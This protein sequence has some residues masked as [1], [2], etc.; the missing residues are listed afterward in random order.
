MKYNEFKA[1]IEAN[2]NL[3]TYRS[4]IMDKNKVMNLTGHDSEEGVNA[5]LFYDSV[6]PF[7]ALGEKLSESHMLDIGSG[8]G[9]PGLVLK[10][11]TPGMRLTIIEAQEKRCKF[12]NDV[13]EATGITGVEI[14]H[15]RA[16]MFMPQFCEK[17]DIATA[18]AVARLN[19]LDEITAPYVKIGGL[20]I[21]PKGSHGEIELHE[22]KAGIHKLGLEI[23]D[24]Q[25]IVSDATDMT[26]FI[27]KCKK[28]TH[29]SKAYP[30][31]WADIKKKPL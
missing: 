15:G 12:M 3:K 29:T 25:K 26:H 28:A 8:A 6:I 1:L 7:L 5:H 16:E 9:F 10:M 23:V 20:C 30:R 14:I 11:L 4:M 21:Y 24:T 27:I 13:V 18:R 22:A 17:F 2:D 19:V 31:A